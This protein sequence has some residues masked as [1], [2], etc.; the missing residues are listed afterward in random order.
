MMEDLM[1]EIRGETQESIKNETR[2]ET[3]GVVNEETL[4]PSGQLTGVY[5]GLDDNVQLICQLKFSSSKVVGRCVSSKV[6]VRF[7][8]T[9]SGT[10]TFTFP[11]QIRRISP[12]CTASNAGP[13]FG[14]ISGNGDPGTKIGLMVS[15]TPC[16]SAKTFSI[17]KQ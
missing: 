5:S 15:A 10:N 2:K 9:K 8:G 14:Q 12:S 7:I 1:E 4:T 16:N 13:N 6:K 17:V 11:F 3:G